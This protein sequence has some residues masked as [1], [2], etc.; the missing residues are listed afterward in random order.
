[1]P[2][3]KHKR[4]MKPKRYT[5][6]NPCRTCKNTEYIPLHLDTLGANE[7][8]IASVCARCT[9]CDGCNGSTNLSFI[10]DSGDVV[11]KACAEETNPCEYCG[12][13]GI[14]NDPVSICIECNE[15]I[16]VAC[17][18]LVPVDERSC[19]CELV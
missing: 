19:Q 4:K 2:P 9:K 16:C 6:P 10:L 8:G 3:T 7:P 17:D 18:A 15:A 1:M 13:T 14:S 5:P 11:C 12:H